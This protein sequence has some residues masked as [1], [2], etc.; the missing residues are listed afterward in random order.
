MDVPYPLGHANEEVARLMRQGAYFRE[1]TADLLRHAGIGPG[2]RVLDVGCGV[3]DVTLLAAEFVGPTGTAI[4]VDREEGAVAVAAKRA[5]V[6]GLG[7]VQFRV[8][9]AATVVLDEPVDAVVGR[10]VLMYQPDPAAALRHLAAQA[11]PGGIVAFQ[12]FDMA[13]MSA[14]PPCPLVTEARRWL[15]ETFARLGAD[16]R[17]GVRLHRHFRDAG[18]AAP[19]MMAAARLGSGRDDDLYDQLLGIVRTLLPEMERIGVATA[20]AVDLPTFGE[21]LQEEVV[22]A[23]AVVRSPLLIGASTRARG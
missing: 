19:Q 6:A 2:M 10:F 3:G 13:A 12:E 7:H 20:A 22:A 8:A 21:R 11:R 1:L 18:L 4:G 23:D 16:P 5:E 15:L 9:D 17:A 14:D